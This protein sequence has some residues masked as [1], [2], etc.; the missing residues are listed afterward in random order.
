MA[1]LPDILARDLDLVICGPAVSGALDAK[2]HYYADPTNKFWQ[3]LSLAGLTPRTLQPHEDH[4]L[5]SFGIGLTDLVKDG[6]ILAAKTLTLFQ[7]GI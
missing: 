4:E 3:I 1:G 5:L 2:G 7:A 6:V